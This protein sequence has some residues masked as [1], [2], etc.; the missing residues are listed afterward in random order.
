M[1]KTV[2]VTGAAS[3]TGYA[4]AERYAREGYAVVTVNRRKPT[5]QPQR[6]LPIIRFSPADMN[7][8]SATKNG[9]KK[10]LTIRIKRSCSLKPWF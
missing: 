2:F 9:S 7:W 1:T 10:F 4:I 8:I 5:K 3:G 6:Y